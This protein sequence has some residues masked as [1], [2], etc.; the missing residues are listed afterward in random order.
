MSF[1]L[2][3]FGLARE[4]LE[5][6][7]TRAKGQAESG[8]MAVGLCYLGLVNLSQGNSEAALPLFQRS[9]ELTSLPHDLAVKSGTCS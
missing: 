9:A 5:S 3:D 6:A 7:V 1:Y 8:S 4:R 2:G